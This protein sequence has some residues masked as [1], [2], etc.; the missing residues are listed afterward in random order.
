MLSKADDNG[1]TVVQ[2]TVELAGQ[3][4]WYL[5]PHN[6][7][8]WPEADGSFRVRSSSQVCCLHVRQQTSGG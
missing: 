6:A 3:Q 5:E 1:L 4:H 8:V 2:G 7:V